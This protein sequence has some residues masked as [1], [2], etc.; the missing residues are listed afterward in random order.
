MCM[1]VYMVAVK[2]VCLCSLSSVSAKGGILYTLYT[3]YTLSAKGGPVPVSLGMRS[4]SDPTCCRHV[5][6]VIVYPIIFMCCRVWPPG[7]SVLLYLLAC[8]HI[9]VSHHT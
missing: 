7:V 4:C 5:L 8:W 1:Y 9:H 3:M 6:P 2:K